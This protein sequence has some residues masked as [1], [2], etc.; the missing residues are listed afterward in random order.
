[1]TPEDS[2]TLRDKV[3]SAAKLAANMH[4]LL[5]SQDPPI[6]ETGRALGLIKSVVDEVWD[7][8]HLNLLEKGERWICLEEANEI[9]DSRMRILVELGEEIREVVAGREG[10]YIE[11]ASGRE[12]EP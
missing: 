3:Y 2:I 9:I 11:G 1:M 8:L 7:T 10:G 12:E 6:A 5:T 4:K